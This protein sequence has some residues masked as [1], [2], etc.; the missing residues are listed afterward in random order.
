MRG[1]EQFSADCNAVPRGGF[2]F[3]QL[4]QSVQ[5]QRHLKKTFSDRCAFRGESRAGEFQ[6]FPRHL[7]AFAVKSQFLVSFPQIAGQFDLQLRLVGQLGCDPL[8]G[9]V[10]NFFE[11]R[12]V[13]SHGARAMP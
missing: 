3:V 1:R 12:G 9:F 13:A 11:Q 7:R 10:E 5:R 6:T 8:N 4:A 2:C